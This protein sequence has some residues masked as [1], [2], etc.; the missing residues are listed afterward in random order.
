MGRT[1]S[2]DLIFRCL[3][4][5]H[6]QGTRVEVEPPRLK[7]IPAKDASPSGT[8]FTDTQCQPQIVFLLKKPS[9]SARWSQSMRELALGASGTEQVWD[10][11]TCLGPRQV[12]VV[13]ALG[14]QDGMLAWCAGGLGDSLTCLSPGWAEG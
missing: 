3:S 4:Q 13:V 7:S 1:Q 14:P 9:F 10:S 12:V 8:G 11:R 2:L 6:E 5:A